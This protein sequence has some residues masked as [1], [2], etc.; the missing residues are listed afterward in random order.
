MGTFGRGMPHAQ[1][2]RDRSGLVT[3]GFMNMVNSK[4]GNAPLIRTGNNVEANTQ[5]LVFGV[6]LGCVISGKV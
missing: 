4:E 2:W 5:Y 3:G 6:M 1:C